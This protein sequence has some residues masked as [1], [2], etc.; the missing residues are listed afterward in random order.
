MTSTC[1]V[2]NMH[3]SNCDIITVLSLRFRKLKFSNGKNPFMSSSRPVT[4]VKEEDWILNE[5]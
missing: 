5:I 4:M 1:C 2:T 3:V